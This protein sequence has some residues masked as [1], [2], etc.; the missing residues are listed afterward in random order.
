M[1]LDINGTQFILY[2]K[3]L[4]VDFIHTAMIGRQGLHLSPSDLK[5]NLL[6]FGFSFDDRSIERIFTETNHYAE[7]F[8][9]FLGSEEIHSL[10]YS[11]YEGATYP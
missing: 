8:F 3:T 4:G 2:A 11:G 1:G 6:K 9:R 10:D 5:A 7:E